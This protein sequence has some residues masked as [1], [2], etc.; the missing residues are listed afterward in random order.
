MKQ[1]Y[2]KPQAVKVSL[3]VEQTVLGACK[4]EGQGAIGPYVTGCSMLTEV[5]QELSP[6]S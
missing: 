5:C 2:K 1:E 6:F 3:K 4:V